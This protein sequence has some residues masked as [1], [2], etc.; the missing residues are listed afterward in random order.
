[1]AQQAT[2]STELRPLLVSPLQAAAMLGVGRTTI[3]YLTRNGALHAIRIGRSTRYVVSDLE[4]YVR[5]QAESQHLI[6]DDPRSGP[7]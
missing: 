6:F 5:E 1:M 3:Y 2:V 4:D 7:K